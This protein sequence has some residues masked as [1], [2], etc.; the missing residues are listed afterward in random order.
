M[1]SK[2]KDEKTVIHLFSIGILVCSLFS[3]NSI[4]D[5]SLLPRLI[6]ISCLILICLAYSLTISK[7]IKPTIDILSL[8]FLFFVLFSFLTLIWTTNKALSYLEISKL[9][10]F[11][12][13]F[14][15]IHNL[16][17][18][19]KD[20]FLSIILKTILVLFFISSLV[21]FISLF[22]ISDLSYSSVYS[23]SSISGHKNIYAS[24]I[25]LTTI[26][27]FFSLLYFTKH[28]KIIS[29]IAIVLQIGLVVVLRSRAVWIGYLVSF[30]SFGLL[31]LFR[32]LSISKKRLVLFTSGSVLVLILFLLVILPGLI[33]KYLENKPLSQD[34]EL[35][36]DTGTFTER[37][38][39]WDKTYELIYDNVFVGVGAGNWKICIPE[40]TLPDIYKVQDLNVIFQRPHNEFIGILAQYGIFGFILMSIFGTSLL[41][42]LLTSRPSCSKPINQIL[43]A[44]LLG[45]FT[46][47]FFSFPLERAEHNILLTIILGI[48]VYQ[49]RGKSTPAKGKSLGVPKT[50]QYA[51]LL[52]CVFATLTII[53]NLRGEQYLKKMLIERAGGNDMEVVALCDSAFSHYYTVDNLSTPIHWYRG[54]ANANM[55]DF[56]SALS[57]FKHAYLVHPFHPHVLNDLGSAYYEMDQIDSAILFLK[58]AVL[59]NPRYDEPL[60]NLTIININEGNYKTAQEW[61][62]SIFHESERRNLYREIIN[63]NLDNN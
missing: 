48:S 62:E 52:A 38:L 18:N 30:S 7:K 57:D 32:H 34:I 19:Y 2:L 56:E 55:K 21:I 36:S 49:I 37:L 51:A 23:L 24:F 5:R 8:P 45:F 6:C 22:Q 14:S 26:C 31:Y 50:G 12:L 42:M 11:F 60:L 44:G 53:L 3:N 28:W 58:K 17:Y 54:N 63:Q 16:L 29:V 27:S 1:I 39:V 9:I 33:D 59:I 61:N 10:L 4:L 46:I 43:I 35:L 47:S 15:I 13:L 40:Y 41:L 25:F 20:Q